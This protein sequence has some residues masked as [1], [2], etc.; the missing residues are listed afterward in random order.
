[1]EAFLLFVLLLFLLLLAPTSSLIFL[2]ALCCGLKEEIVAYRQKPCPEGQQQ[3]FPIHASCLYK[4]A[5]R[6]D[7]TMMVQA[8]A[9][10]CLQQQRQAAGGS[11]FE[12]LVGG[13]GGG[14]GG[15]GHD[16][17]A[18][19]TLRIFLCHLNTSRSHLQL[20]PLSGSRPSS[21]VRVAYRSY[22]D[23]AV[24]TLLSHMPGLAL[25]EWLVDSYLGQ[26]R[27]MAHTKYVPKPW[28]HYEERLDH[29]HQEQR[30]IKQNAINVIHRPDG[31]G[32]GTGCGATSFTAAARSGNGSGVDPTGLVRVLLAH[33]EVTVAAAT[34]TRVLRNMVL[35]LEQQSCET[36]GPSNKAEVGTLQRLA[37][38]LPYTLLDQVL[39]QCKAH[40]KD[41]EKR[42]G[43]GD[44]H[45][46]AQAAACTEAR[47]ALEGAMGKLFDK[48]LARED[49]LE[50]LERSLEMES[51]ST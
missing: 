25:P 7:M 47:N 9:M 14:G 46:Q 43:D 23:A 49:L 51:S 18:W 30:L 15:G 29:E 28:S 44:T 8:L 31:R 27:A 32:I 40:G 39:L 4:L 3:N 36:R 6:T 41:L 37:L 17:D 34:C 42:H 24:D 13:C 48:M 33:G 11:E 35:T 12:G 1:V 16:V 22:H 5:A 45:A 26:T 21:N 20:D 50:N 10:L 2:T 19:G 38:W